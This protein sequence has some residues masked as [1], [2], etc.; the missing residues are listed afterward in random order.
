MD[1]FSRS[2]GGQCSLFATYVRRIPVF[3]GWGSDGSAP[4]PEGAVAVAVRSRFTNSDLFMDRE[5]AK[6]LRK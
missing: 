2:V 3:V 5:L 1:L 4:L 6:W